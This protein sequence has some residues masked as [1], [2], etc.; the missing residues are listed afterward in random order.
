MDTSGYMDT[1][2]R[3]AR[4]AGDLLRAEFGRELRVDSAEQFDLKLELDVR[5]QRLISEILLADHPGHAVL[6]EEGRAGQPDAEFEWIVDPIDGTVNFYYNIPHFCI[7]IALRH[8]ARNVLGVIY[9]P[10]LDELWQ[11]AGGGPATLNGRPI[12]VSPRTRLCEA[13]LTVGF[14]K[15]E[16]TI[17][18][19]L[20]LLTKYVYKARKCRMMGSAALG[21]A[22]VACG[23]LDA[24]IESGIS[25]WDVAAGM[26][27]VEAAGGRVLTRDSDSAPGRMAITAWNGRLDL[28][29]EDD[30]L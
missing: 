24:F 17:D 7:S 12:S 16:S 2:L 29:M 19:G 9:D 10:M 30:T 8:G 20:P 15:S 27:L 18:A 13:V 6:G 14:A 23:R 3:A 11:V 22:Y 1:A 21:M 26:A 4:A 25:I 28:E 5:S